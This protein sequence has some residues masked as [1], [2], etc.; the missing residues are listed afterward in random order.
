MQ[1]WPCP[2]KAIWFISL[3]IITLR[4]QKRSQIQL[5]PHSMFLRAGVRLTTSAF[6]GFFI[7]LFYFTCKYQ[8]VSLRKQGSSFDEDRAIENFEQ[9]T[10]SHTCISLMAVCNC[11]WISAVPEIPSS[12]VPL[13]FV[14]A[15]ARA[16]FMPSSASLLIS[17]TCNRH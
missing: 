14:F 10:R 15:A 11:F 16:A 8:E 17:V 1:L 5:R 12:E 13:L 7:F 4:G 9:G 3:T 6:P 2:L